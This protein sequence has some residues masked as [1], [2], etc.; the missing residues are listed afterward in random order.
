MN[1][2]FYKYEIIFVGSRG[3]HVEHKYRQTLLDWLTRTYGS[4]FVHFDHGSGLRGHRLNRLYAS[5][6]IVIGDSCNPGFTQTNYW[7]DRCPETL[8]RGGFLIHPFV[9]GMEQHFTDQEHLVYYHFGDFDQLKRLIDYY[10]THDADRER[11]RL[12]GH[13]WVKAHH[14]YTHRVKAMLAIVAMGKGRA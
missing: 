13:A 5:A 10:L 7:S 6:K 8:G 2:R 9:P 12:A 1:E 11:I 3:Y 14:T 4:R